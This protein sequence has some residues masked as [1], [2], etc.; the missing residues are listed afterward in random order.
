MPTSTKTTRIQV[1]IDAKT[2]DLVEKILEENGLDVPTAIRI[3]WKQIIHRKGIPF[4]V[5]KNDV[6]QK[7]E[8]YHCDCD[9][10]C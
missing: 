5:R 8:Q 1:K 2:H 4:S 6:S 9:E 3:F 7:K 10:I